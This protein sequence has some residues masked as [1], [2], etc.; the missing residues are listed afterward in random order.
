MKNLLTIALALFVSTLG[1]AA[2]NK[3]EAAKPAVPK[4]K[5]YDL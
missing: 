3:N 1:H 2:K 4:K 5:K